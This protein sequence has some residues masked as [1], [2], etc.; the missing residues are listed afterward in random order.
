MDAF[1]NILN[2]A[3]EIMKQYYPTAQF[4]DFT[5]EFKVLDSP[6]IF[7]FAIPD[8][9]AVL[10]YEGTGFV[11]P[12]EKHPP[13]LGLRTIPLLI[14]LDDA[15]KQ[16][17][18]APA[19]ES[20]CWVLYPGVD[21]PNYVFQNGDNVAFVGAFDGKLQVKTIETAKTPVT[22]PAAN[23]PIQVR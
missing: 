22:V 11:T 5:R 10:K 4:L 18:F 2:N 16:V 9:T 1:L 12:P 14:G 6:Y 21:Q 19:I 13:R 8:G 7:T 23:I 15:R 17:P 3:N 20:L